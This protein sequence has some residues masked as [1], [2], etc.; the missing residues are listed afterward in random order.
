MS[1]SPGILLYAVRAVCLG[2][3]GSI[4]G[5]L[6]VLIRMATFHGGEERGK[7]EWKERELKE[8]SDRASDKGEKG[9]EALGKPRR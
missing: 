3:D 5:G 1:E 9:K 8:R 4:G 7:K 6:V 2:V